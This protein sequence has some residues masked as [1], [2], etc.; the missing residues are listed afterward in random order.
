MERLE[1]AQ[2][3]PVLFVFIHA[4]QHRSPLDSSLSKA[5][6]ASSISLYRP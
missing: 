3:H 1:R 4:F 5:Y 2:M 6:L